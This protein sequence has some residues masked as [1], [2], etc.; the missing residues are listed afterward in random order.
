MIFR[1]TI[2]TCRLSIY[3]QSIIRTNLW[4]HYEAVWCRPANGSLNSQSFVTVLKQTNKR[5]EYSKLT[6]E[7]S[8]QYLFKFF[9]HC[10]HYANRLQWPLGTWMQFHIKHFINSLGGTNVFCF[11]FDSIV[12]WLIFCGSLF[13][14]LSIRSIR[15]E[16]VFSLFIT[17]SLLHSQPKIRFRR[18]R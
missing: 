8:T 7:Q 15:R 2:V 1:Y 3:S 17:I 16:I 5:T 9:F 12:C 14:C 11:F 13:F 18:K 6:Q 10:Q 4:F